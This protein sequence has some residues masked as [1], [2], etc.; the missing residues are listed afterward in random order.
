MWSHS[1]GRSDRIISRL[2]SLEW[3]PVFWSQVQALH[4]IPGPSFSILPYSAYAP[5]MRH[6]G[7][8]K[9]WAS[10]PHG[11]FLFTLGAFTPVVC[12]E[13]SSPTSLTGPCVL[14]LQLSAQVSSLP[15]NQL[16]APRS[17]CPSSLL[18]I[19]YKN[20]CVGV[21]RLFSLLFKSSNIFL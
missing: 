17:L 3:L 20:I 15:G 10:C 4:L 7:T 6:R 1:K 13:G 18:I 21:Y 8:P 11:C 2:H 14:I 12:L 9:N 19:G 16:L 5:A